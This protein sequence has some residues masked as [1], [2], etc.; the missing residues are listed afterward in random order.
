MEGLNL[1]KYLCH[2]TC[3]MY[4]DCRILVMELVVISAEEDMLLYQFVD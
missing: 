2:L 4:A 1:T 3:I